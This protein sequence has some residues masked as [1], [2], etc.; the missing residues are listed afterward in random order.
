MKIKSALI[1]WLASSSLAF[2]QA[3][4]AAPSAQRGKTAPSAASTPAAAPDKSAAKPAQADRAAAY[5]HYA[6]A[7]MYE[8]LVAMYNRSE[9]ANK[10]IDEYKLAIQSDPDS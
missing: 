9:F 7:H 2:S 10:A 6:M 5:Y 3:P 8:E 4:A 1:L